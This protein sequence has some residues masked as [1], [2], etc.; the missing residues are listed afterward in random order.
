VILLSIFGKVYKDWHSIWR[1]DK[2][3]N[4]QIISIGL[5]LRSGIKRGT[6]SQWHLKEPSRLL[7]GRLRQSRQLEE[8]IEGAEDSPD[9]LEDSLLAQ[10]V[11]Q[12]QEGAD[13]DLEHGDY[14]VEIQGID[15][16]NYENNQYFAKF[17]FGLNA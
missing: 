13:E 3:S 9:G 6:S 11:E 14:Q 4:G 2:A 17:Y 12:P 7:A 16:M 8:G 15:V 1:N 10:T 5:Q